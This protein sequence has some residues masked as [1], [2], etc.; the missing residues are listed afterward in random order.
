MTHVSEKGGA[1]ALDQ[2]LHDSTVH[3]DTIEG[4]KVQRLMGPVSRLAES[5][6]LTE[7]NVTLID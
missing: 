4:W 3:Q 1:R 6:S 5:P 2:T 7:E